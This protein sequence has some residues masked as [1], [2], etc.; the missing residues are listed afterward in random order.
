MNTAAER[1]DDVDEALIET[2]PASDPAAQYCVVTFARN[3]RILAIPIEGR[4]Q[5]DLS[6]PS[7][8]P[9]RV[10][11]ESLARGTWT[12]AP[13]CSPIVSLLWRSRSNTAAN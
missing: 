11:E 12:R 3:D 2:F 4:R 9:T 5:T 7:E 13:T 8:L 1:D 10:R 6:S